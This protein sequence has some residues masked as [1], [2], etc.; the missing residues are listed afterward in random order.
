MVSN[1]WIQ[2]FSLWIKRCRNISLA[3]F[4]LVSL[5]IIKNFACLVKLWFHSHKCLHANLVLEWEIFTSFQWLFS[6]ILKAVSGF[7]T[8]CFLHNVHSI[9]Y[10]TYALEQLIWWKILYDFW[11]CWLVKVDV[12]VTIL[13]HR[14]LPFPKQG[15]NFPAFKVLLFIFFTMSFSI[16][17]LPMSSLIFFLDF[18]DVTAT[19]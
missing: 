13:Q 18:K 10:M 14:D 8:Y 4:V 19:R 6:L 16:W 9:N 12:V 2:K 7:P 3:F 17:L 1:F 15:E 11:I 5:S